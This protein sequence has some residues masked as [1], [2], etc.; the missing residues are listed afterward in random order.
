MKDK[1]ISIIVLGASN[2]G[3]TTVIKV[4]QDALLEKGFEVQ[5]GQG[6]D[7]ELLL[8]NAHGERFELQLNA[9]ANRVKIT[10]LEKP[11]IQDL[12]KPQD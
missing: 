12:T 7:D 10:L 1:E 4:I 5:Y 2:T 9:V 3:K 8:L 11:A 6:I